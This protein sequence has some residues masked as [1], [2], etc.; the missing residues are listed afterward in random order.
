[1]TSYEEKLGEILTEH[2]DLSEDEI[3]R[4]MTL[5]SITVDSLDMLQLVVAIEEEFDITLDDEDLRQLETLGDMF[6]RIGERIQE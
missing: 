2:F 6:D 3:S 5:E 1:M 4:E